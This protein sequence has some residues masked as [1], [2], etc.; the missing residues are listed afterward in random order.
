MKTGEMFKAMQRKFEKEL[1]SKKS[2]VSSTKIQEFNFWPTK[3][4]P[5]E[6]NQ[7]NEAP[8]AVDKFATAMA[9]KVHSARD[10][11]VKPPSS[12]KAQ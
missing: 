10:K 1:D 2:Q 12:T 8:P 9:K 7:F 5:L 3:T 11:T 6:R 4:K